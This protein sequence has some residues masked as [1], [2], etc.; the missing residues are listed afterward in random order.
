MTTGAS[1]LQ[2]QV[3][4][5]RRMKCCYD[6]MVEVASIG[7]KIPY[8]ILERL[9]GIDHS[10]EWSALAH[11]LGE[12]AESEVR[13]YNRPMLS[14]IVIGKKGSVS[15]RVLRQSQRVRSFQPA[16]ARQNEVLG[17][18]DQA[19]VCRV[20]QAALRYRQQDHARDCVKQGPSNSNTFGA[21]EYTPALDHL[22]DTTAGASEREVYPNRARGFASSV[23]S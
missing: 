16:R 2:E 6:A 21:V 14:A 3:L 4:H 11:L 13:H 8:G 7:G 12:I 18:P 17:V 22:T 20:G 9:C 10:T 5:T 1:T 15:D 19:G 23:P